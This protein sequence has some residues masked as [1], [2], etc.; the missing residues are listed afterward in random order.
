MRFSAVGSLPVRVLLL[1][2]VTVVV[3]M[4]WFGVGSGSAL[5]A[6][7]SVAGPWWRVNVGGR[8][9][10]LVPGGEGTVVVSATNL[11]DAE[12]SGKVTVR[13]RLPEGMVADKAYLLAGLRAL[14]G[15]G[16]CACLGSEVE[17]DFEGGLPSYERL[18]V[19]IFVKIEEDAVLGEVFDGVS[20]SGGGAPGVSVSDPLTVGTGP[21]GFGVEA[22]ELVPE[23]ADG[24]VDTQAGSHP[25]QLTATTVLNAGVETGGGPAAYE[26]GNTLGEVAQPAL[27]KDLRYDLPP[28]LIG[29]PS[30]FPQC[31]EEEFKLERCPL[32]SQVGVAVVTVAKP[33]HDTIS[34]PV[35][36][37]VPAT[38]EP[39]RFGF[40]DTPIPVFIDTSIR[41]GENYGVVASV[42]NLTQ[43]GAAISAQVSFW[44]WPGDP[45]HDSTR[46]YGC[47]G[48]SLFEGDCT[49]PEDTVKAPFLSLPTSCQ[50][51]ELFEASA[52]GEP[53]PAPGPR[54]LETGPLTY[55][56]K[57]EFGSPVAMDGCNK[58]SFEPSIKVAPDVPEAS[59]STGLSVDL[60]VP[61]E[62]VLIPNG[63][64]ESEVKETT[65]TLPQG[66]AVNPSGSDGL[67]A[68]SESEVG[69]E[70]GV[71]PPSG[72]PPGGFSFSPGLPQLFCPDASKVGTVTI[73]TPLLPEPLEG[74]VY[75]ARQEEN[76]FKSL[77]AM[78]VVA[79]DPRAGVLVKL[80]GEVTLDPASGQLTA[81]FAVPQL[82]FEDGIFHFFGGERAPLTT[83]ALCKGAPGEEGYVTTTA[84]APWSGSEATH[85]TSEFDIT[86]GPKGSPCPNNPK[87]FSPALSQLPFAPS[88]TAGTTSN[89]AGGFSPFTVTMSREDGN[90]QLQD[91]QLQ[92][93]P[94]LLGML[95]SVKL[96]EEAQANTGTCG[97]ESLIGETTVSVGVGGAPFT[98]TGGKV[99][100]TGPYKGAP[101]GLSIVN[102]A[103]AGPFDLEHT[104]A[105]D[106]VCD[107]LVVRARIEVSPLTAALTVTANSGGEEDSIP[108]ILEGIPLQIKHVNV[109]INRAGFT[110]NPTSCE[111]LQI[112]GTLK[113]A[114]GATASRMIPFQV[115]NCAALAFKPTFAGSTAG[116]TSRTQGASLTTTVTYPN[117]PQGTEANIAK[118]KV[119]L[120]AKLPARLTT[121][122]KAC[123]EKTFA[124]SPAD[125]P[126][127][128][129]IGQAT[130]N[131]PVLPG[132]LSGPAYFVSHGGAKYPELVIELTGDN[133]TVDLHG[134]TSISKKGVL[135]STFNT[136][137]DAPF[138]SFQ[139][140]LPKGPYSVL[141]ANGADLCNAGTLTM[142]TELTAQDGGAPIKQNT[143]ITITGCP[144]KKTKHKPPAK[145]KKHNKK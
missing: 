121:L 98:V 78:Y 95:S 24:S 112:G 18:E 71:R 28:G 87:P 29:N 74:A 12:T 22:F 100:I 62:E 140:T 80:P 111:P 85:P 2:F 124:E 33:L 120:P 68:C 107:C 138:S 47:V 48:A 54:P 69:Y 82:P 125:C 119:S 37:M 99:Y 130:T 70:P 143:K 105:H 63:L 13:D 67:E 126:A 139:L 81:K 116:H 17:C 131:T 65:V 36:N 89:Q 64:A 79:E 46:G 94:G 49:S 103:K 26:F 34:V 128:S 14:R 75:L 133:V 41:T 27:P 117:T 123:P 102:P 45:R 114:E 83:P 50:Q 20:V 42:N 21:P 56:L 25:F 145:D 4:A 72:G 135:T 16:E 96:C 93:P 127:A 88:L 15:S 86:S 40:F 39:A 6:C 77:L 90:Q 144:K 134:E 104:K 32:G 97:P 61:Q 109:T 38:G 136:I 60:H 57:D 53:W 92:M 51:N 10:V 9:S 108:T 19:D 58:L 31:K 43:I 101:Y 44:G 30:P 23:N 122:Q 110:F 106:P 76:P 52:E 132:P 91:I 137:P 8:P 11:G 129:R 115:T 7:G 84:I 55:A 141:T 113:S 3:L 142:P 35:F 5:S 73:K 1:V 59:G 118:V 66:V